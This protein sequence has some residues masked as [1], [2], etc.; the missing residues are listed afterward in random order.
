MM[1]LVLLLL[2]V[3][4]GD[5]LGGWTQVKCWMMLNYWNMMEGTGKCMRGLI[6][7]GTF[8]GGLNGGDADT[9][10]VDDMK[11]MYDWMGSTSSLHLSVCMMPDWIPCQVRSI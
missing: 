4:K 7:S 11:I 1:P 6:M 9:A 8:F 10:H 2:P 5:G 3:S